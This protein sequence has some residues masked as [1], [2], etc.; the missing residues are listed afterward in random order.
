[1]RKPPE[2]PDDVQVLLKEQDGA[3]TASQALSAGLT[4]RQLRTLVESG[5]RHPFQGVYV[6]P[7]VADPFRTSVRAALLACPS[8]AAFGVTSARL[9][10]LWGLPIWRES[11]QPELITPAGL[12]L[13]SR[14]G[15]RL[16]TG[17]LETE[18]VMVDGL[19]VASLG[20]TVHHLSL[21]LRLDE[22]VCLVDSAARRGWVPV[23]GPSRGRRR[24]LDAMALSD[25]RSESAL[26][27]YIRLLLVRAGLTPEVLQHELVDAANQRYVRLDLAWPSVRLAIEVDGREFHDEPGALYRDRA[28]ANLALLD[29]WRVL[30]FT[31]FDVMRRPEWVVATVRKAL[32]RG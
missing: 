3:M 14:P 30:R 21:R 22:L 25:A 11:E 16:R 20:R 24:L 12:G 27:T 23:T 31:W 28:K 6:A 4:R 19:P 9:H 5:W 32:G 7:G 29:G 10:K 2:I 8:A 17:L 13:R 18:R 26:E 15:L 1:M